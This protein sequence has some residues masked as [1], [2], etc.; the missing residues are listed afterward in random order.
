MFPT[1]S[2][3]SS[4]IVG[5]LVLQRPLS[6]MDVCVHFTWEEMQLLGPA[7]KHLYRSVMLENYSNL[8]SVGKCCRPERNDCGLQATSWSLKAGK[9]GVGLL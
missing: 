5:N 1:N 8:V 3:R 9:W 6:F 4:E 7:Q 2:V